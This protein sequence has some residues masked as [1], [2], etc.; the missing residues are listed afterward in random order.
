MIQLLDDFSSPVMLCFLGT[1]FIINNIV[2]LLHL[3]QSHL[4]S[5]AIADPHLSQFKEGVFYKRRE[6]RVG[7][8]DIPLT[9]SSSALSPHSPLALHH[10]SRPTR[11][12]DKYGFY[13]ISLVVSFDSI[14]IPNSYGQAKRYGG[15]QWQKS[16]LLLLRIKLGIWFPSDLLGANGF[17]RLNSILTGDQMDTRHA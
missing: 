2:H 14:S 15:R 1:C 11:P 6:Q 3:Q 8:S 4:F 17:A 13:H 12:P 7:L 10:S 9:D 16:W 5:D